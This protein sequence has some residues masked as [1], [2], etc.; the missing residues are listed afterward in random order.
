MGFH[1]PPFYSIPHLHLHCIVPPYT[2]NGLKKYLSYELIFRSLND[3]I[4]KLEKK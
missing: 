3:Q 1:I 4:E 2:S